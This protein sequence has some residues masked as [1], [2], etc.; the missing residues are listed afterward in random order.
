[1]VKQ[2]I[3]HTVHIIAQ[4]AWHAPAFIVGDRAGLQAMLNAIADAILQGKGM[5]ELYDN[6]G[7][8]YAASVHR[9]ENIADVPY[10]YTDEMARTGVPWPDWLRE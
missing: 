9:R 8:G 1:M 2:S 3:P 4:H 5:A 6:D 7:E 10:G